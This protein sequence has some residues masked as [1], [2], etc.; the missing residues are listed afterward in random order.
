[1]KVLDRFRDGELESIH[2]AVQKAELRTSGEIVTYIVGE[3]DGYPEAAWR[4]ATLGAV[5]GMGLGFAGHQFEGLWLSPFWWVVVPSLLGL[6]LGLMLGGKVSPIRR[7][8]VR[9]D[10]LTHRV[11]MRAESAFLE[12]EVFATR[13]RTGILLFVALF[14][15]R[16]VVL[17]DSGIN[18]LVEQSEWT[19][20]IEHMVATLHEGRPAE[21]LLRGVDDCGKL[22][23]RHGVEIRHD[24][25]DELDNRPR[26]R[27]R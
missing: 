21:A 4:G 27:D 23:E 25:S 2:D 5:G 16:V 14:E 1:M 19:E 24:D 22:L 3:C 17:G 15:R 11:G 12:E 8:L 18:A 26:L 10:L 9:N 20:V 13:E 7:W 6:L